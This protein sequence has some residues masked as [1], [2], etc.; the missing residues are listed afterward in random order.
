MKKSK[1]ARERVAERASAAVRGIDP[2]LWAR[3]REHKERT[4]IP[5][6]RTVQDA[7]RDYLDAREKTEGG[8]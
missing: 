8:Q 3:L 2:T 5:V 7:L 6:Y 4:G 1:W